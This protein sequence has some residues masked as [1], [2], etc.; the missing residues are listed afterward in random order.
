MKK[1]LFLGRFPPPIHGAALMNQNYFEALKKE[2][3][4]YIKNIKI[5]YSDSLEEVGKIN[6]KKLI[7]FFIVFFNLIKELLFFR[8]DI[9]YFELAPKGLA[10]FRDSIYIIICKLFR[11][12]ILFHLHAKGLTTLKKN[13]ISRNYAK[14]IFKNTSVIILS[15]IFYYEVK[16]FFRK[17][18]IFII[19]NAIKDELTEKQFE[20]IIKKRNK[21]KKTILLFLS[22]ILKSKGPLDVLKICKELKD[23]KIKFVCNFVGAFQEE[24][25]KKRFYEE[26]KKLELEKE[27]VYLGPKYGKEKFKLLEKTNYL[28]FPTR[29]DAFPIVI[30]EAFMFGIPVFS[31]DTGAIRE[32]ISKNYLG[33]VAKQKD[34]IALY[35]EL[36]KRILLKKDKPQKIREEFKNRYVLEKSVEKLKKVLKNL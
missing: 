9:I 24:K 30:L 34:Y 4:I 17:K 25:F 29:E 14:F 23:D 16:G 7:G 5:N 6:L 33:F 19:P 28:I 11:K 15:S 10:F 1:V 31:Y 35:H 21:N 2:K 3:D 32:I 36:K 22:N 8:P 12:K 27:C 26:L 18:K 20:N 13:F